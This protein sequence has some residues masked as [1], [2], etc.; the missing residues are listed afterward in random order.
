MAYGPDDVMKAM[1]D[2]GD[3]IVVYEGA[4]KAHF[5]WAQLANGG[6]W[7]WDLRGWVR[8]LVWDLLRFQKPV[9]KKITGDFDPALPWGLRDQITRIHLL[10]EQNNW[11]LRKLM[12]ANK[13]PTT[14]MPG[15]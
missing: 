13:L 11:M 5:P 14:G 15:A 4:D 1:F 10:Q 7:A 6:W 2:P 8:Q 9:D 12:D 3:K